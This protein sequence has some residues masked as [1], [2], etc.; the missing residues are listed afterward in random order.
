MPDDEISTK[1]HKSRYLFSIF[2]DSLKI[3]FL[4]NPKLFLIIFTF[5]TFPL[6]ILLTFFSIS[7][8]IRFLKSHLNRLEWLYHAVPIWVEAAN[9]RDESRAD[10]RKLLNLRLFYGVPIFALSLLCLVTVVSLAYFGCRKKKK[11]SLRVAMAAFKLRWAPPLLACMVNF[12]LWVGWSHLDPF[13]NGVYI[14]YSYYLMAVQVMVEVYM[15]AV[16]GVGL[17]VSVIEG[18]VGLDAVIAGFRLMK[19]KRVHGWVLSG[20]ILLISGFI[21]REMVGVMNGGDMEVGDTWTA[22][23]KFGS[24]FGLV[25]LL[26]WFMLWSNVV[27]VVYYFECRKR[28]VIREDEQLDL[29]DDYDI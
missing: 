19:G 7:S 13:F 8:D 25:V 14:K 1:T 10:S 12:I 21:G 3:I 23:M 24:M 9:I 6:S 22:G 5:T 29:I 26:G 17:V 16:M 18:R 28:N 20:F 2:L 27:M 4:E 15:M 11:L